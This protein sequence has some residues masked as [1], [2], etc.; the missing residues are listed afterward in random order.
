MAFTSGR[1]CIIRNSGNT[2]V[3]VTD[4]EALLIDGRDRIV[5]EKTSFE[6]QVD[7]NWK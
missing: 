1:D 3:G 4:G 7:N 2:V 6:Y 5:F